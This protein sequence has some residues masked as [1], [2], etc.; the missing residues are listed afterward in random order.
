MCHRR[1]GPQF[2]PRSIRGVCV[3][4]CCYNLLTE[5]FDPAHPGAAVAAKPH[6]ASRVVQIRRRRGMRSQ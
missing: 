3:V 4:G 1:I 2:T 6:R 5:R